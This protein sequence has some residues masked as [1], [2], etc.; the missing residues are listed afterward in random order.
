MHILISS[1]FYLNNFLAHLFF[2]KLAR[3]HGWKHLSFERRWNRFSHMIVLTYWLPALAYQLVRFSPFDMSSC[4]FRDSGNKITRMFKWFPRRYA[5]KTTSNLRPA[6]RRSVSYITVAGNSFNPS[7]RRIRR[8]CIIKFS[9]Q[10]IHCP[11]QALA[12]DKSIA[13]SFV[14]HPPCHTSGSKFLC[15]TPTDSHHCVELQLAN[16]VFTKLIN[17]RILQLSRHLA[18]IDYRCIGSQVN[19]NSSHSAMTRF[20]G[21]VSEN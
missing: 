8:V 2:L 4:S 18:T 7:M 20:P 1:W 15:K 12:F 3:S 10:R 13:S 5:Q 9:H 6:T 16:D 17:P 11:T 14:V 21:S 19:R